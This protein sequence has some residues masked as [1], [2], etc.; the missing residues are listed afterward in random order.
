MQ[1]WLWPVPC[2][3]RRAPSQSAD[4]RLSWGA[5]SGEWGANAGSF[6]FAPHSPLPTPNYF[7]LNP[8]ALGEGEGKHFLIRHRRV[9]HD[10]GQRHVVEEL[11]RGA[12]GI[13]RKSSSSLSVAVI[14]TG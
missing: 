7:T 4:C 2:P 3:I 1:N 9:Q 11:G 12:M 10:L 13:V 6:V 5:E 14:Q 8:I